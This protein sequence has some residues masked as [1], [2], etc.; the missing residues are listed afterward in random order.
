MERSTSGNLVIAL[1]SSSSC[2]LRH[3]PQ[4][5][6]LYLACAC[7][8]HFTEHDVA[9]DLVACKMRAAVRDDVLCAGARIR[10]EFD[11]RAR[12]LAPFVV[13]L[14]HDGGGLHGRMLVQ[15][16]FDL[17]RRDVLAAGYDDVLRAVLELDVAV[18]MHHAEVAGVKP[19]ALERGLG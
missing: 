16:V 15:G 18:R 4:P 2:S 3:V 13:R 10:L 12:R 6:L 14:G 17:D 5:E 9:R 7:F 11:K 19:A 1:T 8:R